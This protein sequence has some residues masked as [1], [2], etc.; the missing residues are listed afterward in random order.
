[1]CEVF[2]S[3]LRKSVHCHTNLNWSKY[4]QEEVPVGVFRENREERDRLWIQSI[5]R[6]TQA[7]PGEQIEVR[8]L[9]ELLAAHHKLSRDTLRGN[10]MSVV[11]DDAIGKKGVVKFVKGL[12]RRR[13]P[14][15]P[16]IIQGLKG[17]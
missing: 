9:V 13:A 17:A 11:R 10:V 7:A 6:V 3:R 15:A 8:E 16:C 2:E 4:Q 14:E 12:V 1:M 5:L